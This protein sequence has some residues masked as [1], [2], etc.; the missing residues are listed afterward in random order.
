MKSL[1]CSGPVILDQLF[2]VGQSILGGFQNFGVK[3]GTFRILV[4][5]SLPLQ[6]LLTPSRGGHCYIAH[7]LLDNK[8]QKVRFLPDSRPRR[9][10]T[11]QTGIQPH[12][13]ELADGCLAEGPH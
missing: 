2:F 12:I 5:P 1:E 6:W 3:I 11:H 13:K 9:S 8:I 4:H 10:S 7:P